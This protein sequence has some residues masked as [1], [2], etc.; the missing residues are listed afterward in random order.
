MMCHGDQLQGPEVSFIVVAL[1]ESFRFDC[2]FELVRQFGSSGLVP[3]DNACGAW[4]KA[5]IQPKIPPQSEQLPLCR[6]PLRG[7]RAVNKRRVPKEIP[8]KPKKN[9]DHALSSIQVRESEKSH[10][11][12][13]IA[14]QENVEK[15]EKASD[16]K[17]HKVGGSGLKPKSSF[18][19]TVIS[20]KPL[21]KTGILDHLYNTKLL[22]FTKL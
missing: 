16:I 5:V 22:K 15:K 19:T 2:D 20:N 7:F 9:S 6:D 17:F 11:G 13:G 12:I 10:S 21:K 8:K 18:D 3:L 1:C 4:I 14:C